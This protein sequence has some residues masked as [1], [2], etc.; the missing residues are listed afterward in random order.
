M[1]SGMRVAPKIWIDLDNS[2]HV[3]FFAPIIAEL[4]QR[5]CSVVVTARDCSNVCELVKLFQVNAR[6]IGRQYGRRK[7]VK[8]AA[9]CF[10]SLQLARVAMAE[11]PDLAVSHGSRSQLLACA[12][13][14][15]PS[16]TLFD[17]EF[18]SFSLFRLLH[19]M[20]NNWMM[21]PEVIS[22]T[23]LGNG[24]NHFL[25]YP[26]IKEDV[27]VTKFKPDARIKSQLGLREEELVVTVRPPANDAHYFNPE[28]EKV[29]SA[30]LNFLSSRPQ[31][32]IVLLPRNRKQAADLRHRW[33]SA[34]S[35]GKIITPPS[36]VDGLNLIWHSDLVISGGGTMNREAAA[37]GVPVYSVYRGQ[38]GAVDRYLSQTRKLVLIEDAADVERKIVLQHRPK[39]EREDSV[40]RAALQKI[41]ENIF[42]VMKSRMNV[43]GSSANSAV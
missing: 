17:Y 40:N 29:F 11:Q 3:P 2:P 6:V 27:Y 37:L 34:F 8:V 21:A 23:V 42:L 1:K 39:R 33:Q 19:S 16:I 35:S 18:A 25:N 24:K 10:R 28:T 36:A 31:T 13:L 41:V 26:G 20:G 9:T 4:E 32:K 38:T 12:L 30:A 5:G 15:I 43:S 22:S 14:G 7:L